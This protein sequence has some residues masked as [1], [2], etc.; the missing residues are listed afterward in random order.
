MPIKVSV[1]HPGTQHAPNLAKVLGK[2][3]LLLYF[4]TAVGWTSES[5]FIRLLKKCNTPLY[6]K[7]LN[8]TF[9][10]EKRKLVTYPFAELRLH[11]MPKQKDIREAEQYIYKRNAFFQNA[12]NKAI[13]KRSDV[14]IGFDTSSWIIAKRAKEK[15]KKFILDQTI[16]HPSS[17]HNIFTE[18]NNKYPKWGLNNDLSPKSEDLLQLEAAEHAIADAIVVPSHFV[19]DTLVL[20]GVSPDK[21]YLNPFGVDH[22]LFA[23]FNQRD[24][25]A[26][27][28]KFLFVGSINVR[29][30]I[31]DLLQAWEEL[32]LK[33]AELILVGTNQIPALAEAEFID[34]TIRFLG[35]IEKNKLPEIYN[36]AHVFVFPSY[37]E[38]LAQVQLE[39]LSC[40]LPVIGSTNSGA[41]DFIIDGKNGFVIEPGDLNALKKAIDFFI[42]NRDKLAEM[43]KNATESAKEFSWE[44]Y[45]KQWKTIIE[46][47]MLL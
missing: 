47:V 16:G 36:D 13:I 35:R 46:K 4:V 29:K 24:Y 8:R 28:L 7:L 5:L 23:D 21:I 17:K 19:K 45:G 22:D 30:G 44:N 33:N 3:N 31:P 25:K 32:K 42:Q 18:L 1:I 37:F 15:N 6:K 2:L 14:L 12:V 10:I 11:L 40:G 27:T 26:Q 34:P 20:N 41:K 43:S 9:K 38:G 39:A